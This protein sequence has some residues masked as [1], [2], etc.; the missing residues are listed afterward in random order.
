MQINLLPPKAGLI[1]PES[2]LLDA[3]PGCGRAEIAAAAA[4][5]GTN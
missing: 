3:K 1:S 5:R 2:R 4:L